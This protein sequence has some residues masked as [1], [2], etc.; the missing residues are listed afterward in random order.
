[1]EQFTLAE[2]GMGADSWIMF[3]L[4]TIH[5]R[6]G[7]FEKAIDFYTC[8]AELSPRDAVFQLEAGISYE[9]LR[10]YEK[11]EKCYDRIISLAPD[12]FGGYGFKANLNMD[13]VGNLEKARGIL[14][15]APEMD[16]PFAMYR[17]TILERDYEKALGWLQAYEKKDGR[18]EVV[19]EK[20]GLYRLMGEQKQAAAA[21]D[22]ARIVLTKKSQES[23]EDPNIHMNLGYCFAGV[24]EREKAVYHGQRA[25][26]LMPVSRD[27]ILAAVM[28]QDL[29]RIYVEVGD[30]DAA[31]DELDY[32]LSVPSELSVWGLR[33]DP[34]WDPLRENPR[35]QALLKKFQT[36]P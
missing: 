30:H 27:Y 8:G 5:K 21:F 35:Y 24:G 22:S 18:I 1:L 26:E 20:A 15:D 19:V 6:Q 33:L 34:V 2:E 12:K 14:L 16:R 13:R 31:L 9:W 29:A 25:V 7:R 28:R 3:A 17:L 32:L 4:G 36:S 10:Q 23:P 11:A